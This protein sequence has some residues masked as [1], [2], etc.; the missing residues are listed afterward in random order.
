MNHRRAAMALT[1][2]ALASLFSPNVARAQLRSVPMQWCAV[3]G[4]TI[5]TT[6]PA[7]GEMTT[8][9]ALWRR[10]ERTT[11]RTYIP[12]GV[13]LRSSIISNLITQNGS[14]GTLDFPRVDDP[15]TTIGNPG[16]VL[17]PHLSVCAAGPNKNATCSTNT[18]CP[19]SVCGQ[20][21]EFNTIYNRCVQQWV[22]RFCNVDATA[23]FGANLGVMVIN[24]NKIINTNGNPSSGGGDNRG[25]GF[26]GARKVLAED[27]SFTLAAP[28][29]P[30]T[31]KQDTSVSDR[32]ETVIGHEVGHA[33]PSRTCLGGTKAGTPCQ[34]DALKCFGGTRAGAP[35][36]TATDCP[37]TGTSCQV[38]CPSGGTCESG[39]VCTTGGAS[40]VFDSDCPGFTSSTLPGSLCTTRRCQGGSN[41]RQP[42]IQDSDCPG[43][44]GTCASGRCSGG[45]LSS[46]GAPCT[47][48]DDCAGGCISGQFCQGGPTPGKL[49][50]RTTDCGTG[51]VCPVR[52]LRHICRFLGT[53]VGGANAGSDC[54]NVASSSSDCPGGA[55][56]N[57]TCV[58]GISGGAA[59][60]GGATSSEC[61]GGACVDNRTN[62][63]FPD[64][65]QN[66]DG[67]TNGTVF[68]DG[69]ALVDSIREENSLGN[70]TVTSGQIIKQREFVL[71][72]A[73]A[74]PGCTL[75]GA[76]T[77]FGGTTPGA[78]C[79]TVADCPG[80]GTSCLGQHCTA[81]SDVKTDSLL[82][83]SDPFLDLSMLFVTEPDLDA[84][85]VKTEFAHELAGIFSKDAFTKYSSLEYV[86]LADLDHDPTTGASAEDASDLLGMSVAFKG[87]ELITRVSALGILTGAPGS[88][89]LDRVVPKPTLWKF[90]GGSFVK[91][92]DPS[93]AARLDSSIAP[94]EGPDP[95]PDPAPSPGPNPCRLGFD[96]D[97]PFPICGGDCLPG[98]VCVL[99][100]SNDS[101]DQRCVCESEVHVSDAVVIEMSNDVRGE[102]KIPIRIQALTVG[103]LGTEPPVI[104]RLEDRVDPVIGEVGKNF[105]L[106]PAPFPAC[107]GSPDPVG[108]GGHSVVHASGLLPDAMTKV[109]LGDIMVGATTSNPDGT[110]DVPFDVPPGIGGGT[111]LLTVG[112]V[113]TALTADCGLGIVVC[114]DPSGSDLDN[115]GIDDI[116]DDHDA[117]IHIRRAR[118]RRSNTPTGHIIVKGDIQLVSTADTFDATKGIAVHVGDG[119]NLDESFAWP[120]AEC[121]GFARSGI[122]RCKSANGE[123]RGTF[124]ANKSP[125]VFRFAM[126]FQPLNLPGP[127][128][129]FQPDV[130]VRISDDPPTPVVG[131]DRVGEITACRVT[132]NAVVCRER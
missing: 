44:Q 99:I 114:H 59:C 34:D 115:D 94:P 84:A 24:A 33:L 5:A 129:P 121:H 23:C 57:G 100:G 65:L 120:A 36:N 47:T 130:T 109:F 20:A 74:V 113:G 45:S 82:D 61:S 4:S 103:R 95:V 49:C 111:H 92:D 37:G 58:G 107:S 7:V 10:H 43:T 132:T 19:G 18:Q 80:T 122:V 17:D 27:A 123:L 28:P 6:P 101:E 75:T 41:D 79:S 55:C 90:Q 30:D 93:I 14:P 77:C 3:N 119:A 78:P 60:A 72:G 63:L 53:C 118:V 62:L 106:V 54:T 16:D 125:Q 51:G 85:V 68:A 71:E 29:A 8:N 97:K 26:S 91:I 9:D 105:W 52:G 32:S 21:L 73:R 66:I 110:A 112:T 46:N 40:C 131:I 108:E 127:E 22:Q 67:A 70:C 88:E 98:Q 35:C 76:M 96:P 11:D 102:A 104:D 50:E 87:A 64:P 38:Q 83:G 128:R 48:N 13:T 39:R 117:S 12:V 2:F 25:Y 126:R 31:S 86:V 42:C 81:L 15:D 1:L 69:T 116:C 56:V 124:L 89:A